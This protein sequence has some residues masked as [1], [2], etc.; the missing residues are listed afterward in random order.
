MYE[1]TDT[2]NIR[3]VSL[4]EVC[5]DGS[6]VV[7]LSDGM[8][9]R[10]INGLDNNLSDEHANKKMKSRASYLSLDYFPQI[11]R[12]LWATAAEDIIKRR[13]KEDLTVDE[14]S[15]I[16]MHLFPDPQKFKEIGGYLVKG[17]DGKI[18]ERMYVNSGHLLHGDTLGYRLDMTFSPRK[19]F[20]YGRPQKGDI[21]IKHHIH[22]IN[23]LF[24]GED[25]KGGA[26]LAEYMEKNSSLE[27]FYDVL[28]FPKLTKFSWFQYEKFKKFSLSKVLNV[29]RI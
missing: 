14:R 11:K 15:D 6:V 8:L 28:Y 25:I 26:K 23:H 21:L 24:S 13:V 22:P 12:P 1:K 16:L 20:Q 27:N 2:T 5:S 17:E 9:I 18:D 10:V 29:F 7:K 19:I 3:I 4:E